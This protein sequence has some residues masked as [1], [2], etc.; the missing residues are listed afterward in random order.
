M[1]RMSSAQKKIIIRA[2]AALDDVELD[3]AINAFREHHLDV[4]EERI[5]RGISRQTGRISERSVSW[6]TTEWLFG[7]SYDW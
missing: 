6:R 3:T 5:S 2:A 4:V 1:S 7:R